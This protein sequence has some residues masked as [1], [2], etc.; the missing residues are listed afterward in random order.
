MPR[1]QMVLG[2]NNNIPS[3]IVGKAYTDSSRNVESMSKGANVA[4]LRFS[5]IERVSSSRPSCGS[6]GKR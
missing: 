3:Y 4:S 2:Q 5:M 1:M 6:C